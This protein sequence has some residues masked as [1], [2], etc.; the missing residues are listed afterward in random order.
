MPFN[1]AEIRDVEIK[2]MLVQTT[3]FNSSI[4]DFIY[5]FICF[6]LFSK[7]EAQNSSNCLKTFLI[8]NHSYPYHETE[9]F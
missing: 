8:Q 2:L 1:S 7:A 6:A 5:F 9:L 3:P 4:I